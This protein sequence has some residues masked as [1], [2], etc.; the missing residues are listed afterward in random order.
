MRRAAGAGP[1]SKVAS[2][3]AH[4]RQANRGRKKPLPESPNRQ[5]RCFPNQLGEALFDQGDDSHG[6]FIV[7]SGSLEILGISNGDA[8]RSERSG[9]AR[10]PAK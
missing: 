5:T 1:S 10:L 6:V 2:R 9:P 3:A 8:T 4:D 7:V